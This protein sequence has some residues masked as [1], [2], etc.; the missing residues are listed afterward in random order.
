MRRGNNYPKLGCPLPVFSQL[1]TSTGHLQCRDVALASTWITGLSHLSGSVCF[2][3]I[4]EEKRDENPR[5]P[6]L[7]YHSTAMRGHLLLQPTP[8][9]CHTHNC[10]NQG[11]PSPKRFLTV[12]FISWYFLFIILPWLILGEV[13]A[14]TQVQSGLRL[15]DFEHLL[16]ARHCSKHATHIKLFN[17][18]NHSM[19]LYWQLHLTDGK[20]EI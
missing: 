20:T 7:L 3:T 15:K 17:P 19:S 2:K 16:C 9:L 1:L 6:F 8:S 18:H 14:V 11:P 10:S 5:A 4:V 12:S 13:A